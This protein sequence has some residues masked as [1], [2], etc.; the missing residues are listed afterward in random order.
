MPAPENAFVPASR[1]AQSVLRSGTESFQDAIEPMP[2]TADLSEGKRSI[3]TSW[4]ALS[5]NER[6]QNSMEGAFSDLETVQ[7]CTGDST[8]ERM[9]MYIQENME[10]DLCDRSREEL[11]LDVMAAQ[12]EKHEIQTVLDAATSEQQRIRK[13]HVEFQLELCETMWIRCLDTVPGATWSSFFFPELLTL[14]QTSSINL[15]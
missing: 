7:S 13:N 11:E 12:R 14:V 3:E 8:S 10:Q 5:E 6:S 15:S 9:S 4:F 2:E 1:V